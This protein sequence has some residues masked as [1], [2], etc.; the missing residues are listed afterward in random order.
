M[1][2]HSVPAVT[3][4]NM[5][6]NNRLTATCD[7][8][9]QAADLPIWNAKAPTSAKSKLPSKFPSLLLQKDEA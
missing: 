3:H 8:A 7:V 1:P 2:C 9:D 5:S 4:L 6:T